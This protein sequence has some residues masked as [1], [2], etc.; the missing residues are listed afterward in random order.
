[1]LNQWNTP[2]VS[3]LKCL[4]RLSAVSFSDH[5]NVS[6]SCKEQGFLKW[7]NSNPSAWVLM[8]VSSFS[9]IYP[10]VLCHQVENMSL[11][12]EKKQDKLLEFKIIVL[13]FIGGFQWNFWHYVFSLL[14]LI[15]SIFLTLIS[16]ISNKHT[17]INFFRRAGAYPGSICT[18][19]S[20]P[21]SLVII[22]KI[23]G[24]R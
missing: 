10:S 15:L 2:K 4:D 5:R 19:S 11:C 22:I 16:Y 9:T 7:I 17:K 14:I 13:F 8:M 21:F 20:C 1:M 23:E 18:I 24:L 6:Y 3:S 12:N